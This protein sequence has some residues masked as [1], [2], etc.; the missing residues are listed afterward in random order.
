MVVMYLGVTKHNKLSRKLMSAGEIS[1]GQGSLLT[2]AIMWCSELSTSPMLLQ[3]QRLCLLEKADRIVNHSVPA[4][5]A[6]SF[7]LSPV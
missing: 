5:Y 6:Y 3:I 1:M 2:L 7:P 4:S